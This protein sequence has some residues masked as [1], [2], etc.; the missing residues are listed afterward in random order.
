MNVDLASLFSA[1]EATVLTAATPI[2]AWA[3]IIA[4]VDATGYPVPK[5]IREYDITPLV[6]GLAQR[7][8]ALAAADVPPAGLTFYHLGL[9]D[10]RDPRTTAETVGV[11]FAGGTG[12]PVRSLTRGELTYRPNGG[13]LE[14]TFLNALRAAASDLGAARN[15]FEYG[16][17]FGAAAVLARF[18]INPGEGVRAVTVGF[19]GGDYT[20]IRRDHE[21]PL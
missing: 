14:S 21:A 8:H 5:A 9:Y 2:Q 20:I 17:L 11:Y 6:V 7:L 15:V 10:A 13:V 12:D 19:D 1:V 3:G 18:A 16:L 4:V